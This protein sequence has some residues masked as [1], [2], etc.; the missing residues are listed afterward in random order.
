M[1]GVPQESIGEVLEKGPQFL[2]YF[3]SNWPWLIPAIAIIVAIGWAAGKAR[4][5]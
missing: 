1:G 4:K 5:G 2:E 3:N